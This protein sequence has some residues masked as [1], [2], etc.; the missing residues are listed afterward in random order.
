MF[1]GGGGIPLGTDPKDMNK[2]NIDGENIG[3]LDGTALFHRRLYDAQVRGFY[4]R[5]HQK[6]QCGLDAV[7][8]ECRHF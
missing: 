2:E 8:C 6:Q 7:L 4:Q 1:F 3:V 5:L